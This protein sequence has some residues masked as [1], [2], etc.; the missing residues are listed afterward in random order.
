MGKMV[1]VDAQRG[2][3]YI[4]SPVKVCQLKKRPKR[5]KTISFGQLNINCAV[6]SSQKLATTSLL[7]TYTACLGTE[8]SILARYRH[9]AKQK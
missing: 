8:A 2:K 6:R 4:Y 9:G 5:V 7:K 3:E 1:R